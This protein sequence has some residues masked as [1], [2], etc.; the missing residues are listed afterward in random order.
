MK[1]IM[2]ETM[3]GK[4]RVGRPRT[5]WKD[6]LDRDMDARRLNVEEVNWRSVKSSKISYCMAPGD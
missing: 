2:N 5:S 1:I 3:E 4:R 6:V